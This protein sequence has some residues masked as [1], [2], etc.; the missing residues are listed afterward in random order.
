[1]PFLCKKNRTSVVTSKNVNNYVAAKILILRST[2]R[3]WAAQLALF[4]FWNALGRCPEAT[5]SLFA[6]IISLT[7]EKDYNENKAVVKGS[8]LRVCVF[9]QVN[10]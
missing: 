7:L 1:M 6:I 9:L 8:L 3:E 4:L 5:L 2:Y 10:S